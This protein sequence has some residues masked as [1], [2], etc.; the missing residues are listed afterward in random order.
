MI[1][2]L[3]CHTVESVSGYMDG[4]GIIHLAAV[5]RFTPLVSTCVCQHLPNISAI[6]RILF[7]EVLSQRHACCDSV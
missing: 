2:L 4:F 5:S 6:A 3:P 7:R 1:I